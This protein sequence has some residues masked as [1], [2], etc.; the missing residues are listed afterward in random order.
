MSLEIFPANIRLEDILKSSLIFVFRKRL[1]DVFKRS[2]KCLE[3]VL[4]KRFQDIFKTYSRRFE[5]V[6]SYKT[7]SVYLQES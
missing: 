3:D 7:S 2:S 5:Y 6:F 1:Q 4:Q